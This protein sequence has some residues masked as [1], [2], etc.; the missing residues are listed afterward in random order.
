MRPERERGGN[1]GD[2]WTALRNLTRLL[3]EFYERFSSWEQ[4]CGAREAG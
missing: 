4:W 2:I 1:R 3:I